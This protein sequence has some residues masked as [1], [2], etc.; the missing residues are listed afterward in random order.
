MGAGQLV[1]VRG[2]GRR[3]GIVRGPNEVN[4]VT[5]ARG[6]PILGTPIGG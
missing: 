1:K 5:I 2:K 6:N 3:Q 4:M